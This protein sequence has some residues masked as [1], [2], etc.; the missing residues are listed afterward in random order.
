MRINRS[1]ALWAVSCLMM[2]ACAAPT[3]LATTLLV[4][5]STLIS[6]TA[7]PTFVPPSHTP[8]RNS[9]AAP[10]DLLA[11]VLIT[12][13]PPPPTTDA[14]T[15]VVDLIERDPVAAELVRIARELVARQQ[16][17]AIGRVE[18][19]DIM[20]VVWSDSGLNCASEEVETMPMVIDGYRILLRTGEQNILFHSDFDRV[21]ACFF[22]NERLP[23]GVILEAVETTPEVTEVNT[24]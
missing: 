1:Y 9:P 2:T 14:M 6:S 5:T 24:P 18:L 8:T 7:T 4:P 12:P 16:D 10:P 11:T 22:E 23:E 21:I 13:S 15:E 3:P 20:P 19:V 17:I